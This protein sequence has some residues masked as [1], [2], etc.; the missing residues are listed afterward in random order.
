MTVTS[1]RHAQAERT[2]TQNRVGGIHWRLNDVDY[3]IGKRLKLEG[4]M[5]DSGRM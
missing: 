4:E 2:K 3:Y 1:E 5:E